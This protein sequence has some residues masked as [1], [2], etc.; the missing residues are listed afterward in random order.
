MQ[1]EA[2]KR[3]IAIPLSSRVRG[4]LYAR[5]RTRGERW[6]HPPRLFYFALAYRKDWCKSRKSP[7][8]AC[9]IEREYIMSVDEP[10]PNYHV[11]AKQLTEAKKTS[12][13]LKSAN[14]QVLQQTLRTLD[15]AWDDMKNRGFGFLRFKNKYRLRSFVFPQLN[16]DPIS[17]DSIKLPGLK[18][19]RWRMSRPIPDGFVPKQARIVRKASGYFVMLSLQLNV[20]IPS[21][22]PHGHPRGLDLGFDKF[23]ATS[24]GK[25]IK[26]PRFLK[27]LQRKLKLLQ[28]RLRNKQKGSNNRHKLNQKIARA[29]Q[30]ISDTRQDW[31]FK[32]SHQL[33]QNAGM[34]FVEDINFVSWQRGMLSKASAD[35]GFGQFVNILEWVCWKTDTYFAKV[36]KNG[37]SQTCPN[38][39][40]HTSKK[41]L[42]LRIHSCNSCEYITSRDIAAAEVVRNRGVQQAPLA[43][44]VSDTLR[45]SP[46]RARA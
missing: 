27:T 33:V 38:C 6:Q 22:L 4:N 8:N 11:Q 45:H 16:K 28:R 34:I 23:V 40:T 32:L 24:D 43:S 2:C 39:G 36:N 14:A 17:V 31:H 26:R 3:Q 10:F 35:A 9:S 15:R 19:V 42:D 25:E 21:P 44:R 30:R 12:D 37:T 20:D 5:F 1:P 29:N 7:I 18:R 13:F 46:L 41:T